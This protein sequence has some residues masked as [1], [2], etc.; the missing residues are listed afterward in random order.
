MLWLGVCLRFSLLDEHEEIIFT[1]IQALANREEKEEGFRNWYEMILKTIFF[2]DFCDDDLRP[3]L[4]FDIMVLAGLTRARQSG[5]VRQSQ[6]N[7]VIKA[8]NI[9]KKGP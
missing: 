5:R 3:G 9:C 4:L 1:T 2:F 8:V 7:I 6:V